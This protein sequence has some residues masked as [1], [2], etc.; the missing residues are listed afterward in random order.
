MSG[1]GFGRGQSRPIT[2]EEM[3]EHA[4]GSLQ[5]ARTMRTLIYNTRSG[6]RLEVTSDLDIA[7]AVAIMRD[8]P[9]LDDFGMKTFNQAQRPNPPAWVEFFAVKI[10][11]DARRGQYQPQASREAKPKAQ[12]KAKAKAQARKA[13]AKPAD[14]IPEPRQVGPELHALL[15]RA[16]QL[17]YPEIRYAGLQFVLYRKSQSIAVSRK[18][19]PPFA[20]IQDGVLTF[21]SA[22]GEYGPRLD[23]FLADPEGEAVRA[24]K[25]SGHCS[26]CKSPLSTPESV[27]AGYGPVCAKHWGLPWG[28]KSHTAT[29][30][31]TQEALLA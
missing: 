17:R 18:D 30:S 10:A 19:R 12:A 16:T 31:P 2:F 26:F 20:L 3:R 6:K 23:R 9:K 15:S 5:R 21:T 7:A 11:E 27:S 8:I 22:P 13:P 14:P 24:G 4:A 25:L 29:L 28:H 1:V